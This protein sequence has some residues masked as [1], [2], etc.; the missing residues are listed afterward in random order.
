M[1]RKRMFF[2]YEI[3]SSVVS[4][5]KSIIADYDRREKLIKYSNVT[6]AVLDELIKL[7]AIVDRALEDIECGMRR[8]IVQDITYGRGFFKSNCCVMMEKNTY[9]RRRRKLVYDIAVE[10]HL[11]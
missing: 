5:V 6:G 1:A 9:Y 4:I 7:N 3:D 10:L 8:D 11:I 2:K